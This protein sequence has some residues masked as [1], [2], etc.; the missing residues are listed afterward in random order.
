METAKKQ[1]NSA[2]ARN[3]NL[4]CWRASTSPQCLRVETSS[5]IYL[6]PYGYFQHAIFSRKNNDDFIVL[7]FGG[8]SLRVKGKRLESLIGALARLGVEQINVRPAKYVTNNSESVITEIE[9]SK[10]SDPRSATNDTE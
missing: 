6:L 1:S 4:T 8:T 3:E 10:N 7:S 2:E 5:E 9:I